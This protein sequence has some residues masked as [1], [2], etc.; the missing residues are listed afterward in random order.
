MR[1]GI[2]TSGGDC[3]GINA[4]I[5]GVCKTAI[6]HYG[7]EVIGIHSGFQGLLTKD[8]E[9]FTE[10]SLSGLL[11]LGGTMLGT[12]REKPFKKNGVM[13]GVDKPALIARNI[14][15]MG[16][17]CVVCI[18]GNG[19]QKTAAKLSA[20]GLNIVS[21][22]KTIDNDIW[23]TDFS[24]GFDSAVSIATDA[25]DR[26]HSTASSH[27]RVMVIEV[28]NADPTLTATSNEEWCTIKACS[29]GVVSFYIAP[30]DEMETR[31][32][33]ISLVMG[34]S[35]AKIGI[36]QMGII[37]NYKT[38]DFFSFAENKAFKQFIRFESEMP[39]TV[40][41]S[42]EAQTWLS[43]EE[44]EN[45]YYI[46]ADENTESLERLGKVTL[47]SGSLAKEYSFMQYSRSSYN[48]SWIADFKNRDGFATQDEVSVIAESNEV[49]VS[50]KNAELTFKGVLKDG[51]LNVPCGQFLK[52]AN[53]FKLYLGVIFEND[54]WGLNPDISFTLAPSALENGDWVLT[55]QMDQKIGLKI[56]SIAIAAMDEN[57]E[58]AGAMDLLQELMLKPN[59]EAQEIVKTYNV[60]F[61]SAEGSDYG[62]NDNITFSDG[63]Y[64]LAL[65][66]YGED[67][68][69]T[70]SGTYVVGAEDGYY[71]DTNINYT[72]FMKGEEK[73][74][75]QSGAM[76]LNANT[77]TQKYEISMEFI[78]EDGSKVNATYEGEIS[79]EKFAIFDEL[80]IQVNSI[81]QLKRILPNGAVDGQFY[82]KAAFNNW[83]T[84][85]TLDLRA[86]AGE[87]V[88]PA[89][90]YNVGNDGAVGTL[91]SKSSE[92]S[93]YSY[94]FTTRK[95]KSGKV[96][97]DKSG[98]AYTFKIDLTDTEGQRYVC[99]F[100]SKV[101]D[102][103]N[104]Q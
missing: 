23:G 99:T 39:I 84:E 79:G 17:D 33:T 81:E 26:L 69:Y 101:A 14:E 88:L 15:E 54:Q 46:L 71:I 29:N 45:G 77:E 62:R 40:R 93:V 31:T 103:D 19:T 11:N 28:G 16:L 13:S 52:T 86:A 87:K 48:R 91:D 9:S 22:P 66:I 59:G 5:R 74:G 61:T 8:A 70:K 102:M 27:K 72:Y 80:Q 90:T 63:N 41:I 12:S 36:T 75:I 10:K 83:D 60:A 68:K 104:P 89:G 34:E 97:V 4:T 58:L 56:K 32:A 49:T 37:T 38:D 24:F 57:D 7:M 47:E 85:M 3:P 1:I 6:N 2:L 25:I 42:E 35:S 20:M 44:A 73:I 65:D 82:L 30:N 94:G 67:Y 64:T 50:F 53:G 76:K 92:I 78:L 21:V 18:G 95:F 98:E 96:E 100:T 51:V 55:P 43:Y